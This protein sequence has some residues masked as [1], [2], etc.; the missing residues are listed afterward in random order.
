MKSI[1]F[2]NEYRKMK[3]VGDFCKQENINHSNLIKGKST[4]ENENKIA[5]LCKLEIIRLYGEV[6]KENVK[7]TDTL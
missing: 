7:K 4:I 5:S 1:E 3:S 6:I 2:I